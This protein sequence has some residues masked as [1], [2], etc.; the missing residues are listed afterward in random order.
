[1]QGWNTLEPIHLATLAETDNISLNLHSNNEDFCFKTKTGDEEAMS[2]GSDY[3]DNTE[4][5]TSPCK[6][7]EGEN[8][9]E[10]HNI[11][12]EE[13]DYEKEFLPFLGSTSILISDIVALGTNS[14]EIEI[15]KPF[16][17]AVEDSRSDDS[18]DS[19]SDDDGIGLGEATKTVLKTIAHVNM[20]IKLNYNDPVQEFIDAKKKEILQVK[21]TSKSIMVEAYSQ[22]KLLKQALNW[23]Q[24]NI[25]F[26][27]HAGISLTKVS[28]GDQYEVRGDSQ[29]RKYFLW[30]TSNSHSN[31]CCTIF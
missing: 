1:M 31:D 25:R 14:D 13:D 5:V 30:S 15:R 6:P 8:V 10:L 19:E 27:P 4:S 23:N 17:I 24:T 26:C 3:S 9:T 11:K 22:K 7:R 12:E 21:A 18:I 2:E 20:K 16:K 28:Q 29:T